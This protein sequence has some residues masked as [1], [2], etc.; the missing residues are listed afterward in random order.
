ML[1]PLLKWGAPRAREPL[2]IFLSS[3]VTLH[4]V[5]FIGVL[6]T[7]QIK[8]TKTWVDWSSQTSILTCNGGVFIISIVNRWTLNRGVSD[9]KWCNR[10]WK[11][12]EFGGGFIFPLPSNRGQIQVFIFSDRL[13]REV[14]VILPPSFLLFVSRKTDGAK[15]WCWRSNRPLLSITLK[16]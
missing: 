2:E 15:A 16:T 4:L 8:G 12:G 13:C 14:Y 11:C 7:K 10:P 1:I 9:G 6:F 3:A 5:N